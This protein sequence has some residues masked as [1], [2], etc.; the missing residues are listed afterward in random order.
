[1]SGALPSPPIRATRAVVDLD[2][3]RDNARALARAVAPARLWA[4]VKADAYGHGAVRVAQAALEGGADA[5]CVALP[6]EA[7]A[8]RAAGVGAGILVLG[9]TREAEMV[10]LGEAGV[11]VTV[12]DA[13]AAGEARSAARRLPQA[14]RPLAVHLKVDTGMGRIG[15]R[16]EEAPG[17]ARALAEDAH[18]HLAGVFTHLA[19]ADED[20]AFTRWQLERFARAQA[21]VTAALPQ[22][23]RPL[24][25][26]ANSAGALA[27]PRSRLDAV[28]VGIALY[29][30]PAL[31][32]G[33]PPPP[34]L[35]PPLS[36]L[37]RVSF[38]KRVPP[39]TPVSYGATHRTAGERM[40]ATIPAGYADGVRR[41]LTGLEVA[42]AG[43]RVPV[44]GRVTMDQLVVE[45][46]PDW[47]VKVGD[48]AVLLAGGEGPDAAAWAR[49]LGTIPYEV[50]TGLS[51]RV[52]RL[53]V[54]RGGAA[55][56]A[57]EGSAGS[58]DGAAR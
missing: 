52:P 21:E 46:P 3:V 18:L 37:S 11:W 43:R 2:A 33:A 15:C 39:G 10:V 42:V 13:A 50:L 38:V 5:L 9:P 51:A 56:G 26:A 24:W 19:C 58:R 25:H 57:E 53:Y 23:V 8:L 28:R 30:Y 32:P 16:P 44:V 49:H 54:G 22:G 7:L 20:P 40:L 12:A 27:E 45:G 29:G 6:Q 47:E 48:R 1:M 4:V 35:R 17:L 55:T 31:P 41:A 14:A 34:P 36:L